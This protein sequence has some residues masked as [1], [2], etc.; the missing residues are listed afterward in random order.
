MLTRTRVS[1]GHSRVLSD[2]GDGVFRR[3]GGP[4]AG[5]DREARQGCGGQ[6]MSRLAGGE[7]RRYERP[8]PVDDSAD[9]DVEYAV[10]LVGRNLPRCAQ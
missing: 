9:I 8:E 1:Q 2:G 3:A 7:Q 4:S 5:K 10:P 6:H